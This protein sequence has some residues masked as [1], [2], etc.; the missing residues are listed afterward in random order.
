MLLYYI[1][2]IVKDRFRAYEFK[3][4]TDVA[5]LKIRS[6]NSGY[7]FTISHVMLGFLTFW[8]YPGAAWSVAFMNVTAQRNRGRTFNT[9]LQVPTREFQAY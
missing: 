3:G 4:D 8:L 7:A 2:T 6:T 5:V 9:D 1:G